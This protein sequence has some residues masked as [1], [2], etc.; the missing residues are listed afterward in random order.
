MTLQDAILKFPDAKF[1]MWYLTKAPKKPFIYTE[2]VLFFI[3]FFSVA[4]K[5]KKIIVLIPTMLFILLL[6]MWGTIFLI[7]W[8]KQRS[9]EKKRAEAM[10]ITLQEY[11]EL[12]HDL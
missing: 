4:F 7:A 3:G 12:I 1:T 9:V 8:Y 11:Y 10:G 5:F 6:L 2:V